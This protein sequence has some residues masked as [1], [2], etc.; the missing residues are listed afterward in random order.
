MSTTVGRL[1]EAPACG[2]SSLTSSEP[3]SFARCSMMA[4]PWRATWTPPRRRCASV[5][6]ARWA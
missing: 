2:G 3:V 4:T 5:S 1:I 6:G